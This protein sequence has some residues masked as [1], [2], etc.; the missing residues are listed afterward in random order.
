MASIGTEPRNT[1]AL[2]R[3]RN[4]K[5]YLVY[6]VVRHFYL[7]R[8]KTLHLHAHLYATAFGR[9]HRADWRRSLQHGHSPVD[10]R[11]PLITYAAR[12]WLDDYLKPNMTV[13]EYGSGGS[14][15]YFSQRVNHVVSIEHNPAWF[16][17]MDGLIDRDSPQNIERFL[18]P[19]QPLD[20]PEPAYSP[21]SYTSSLKPFQG[22]SYRDYVKSIDAYPDHHF[23]LVLVDGRSR[24]SCVKRAMNKIAKGGVLMLDNSERDS[25]ATTAS[26]LTGWKEQRFFG[27][28]PNCRFVWATSA[29]HSP[30]DR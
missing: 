25:Y 30:T 17:I 22:F 23:D 24:I 19:P 12:E 9:R 1:S 7:E 18:H 5:N 26:I 27:V 3:L 15:F 29:W 2:Q 21:E 20:G 8:K 6:D 14:T 4:L 11:Y 16:K 13:F 10:D 28:G